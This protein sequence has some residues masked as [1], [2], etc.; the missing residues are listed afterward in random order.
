MLRRVC[1]ELLAAQYGLLTPSALL[2][3]RL[4][5]GSVFACLHAALATYPELQGRAGT[6]RTSGSGGAGVAAGALAA[7][8]GRGASPEA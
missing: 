8:G 7:G 6:R 3:A 2:L 1:E 5:V 4:L